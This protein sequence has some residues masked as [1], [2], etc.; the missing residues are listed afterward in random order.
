MPYTVY[1]IRAPNGGV[2]YGLTRSPLLKRW[3]SHIARANKSDRRH[4][5]YDAMRCYGVGTFTCEVVADELT[6]EQACALEIACISAARLNGVRV[7]NIS[8]G[9]E[10][11]GRTGG[12]AFWREIRAD[13]VR[14]AAYLRKCSIAQR[15]AFPKKKDNLRE[16]AK[17]WREDNPKLAYKIRRRATRLSR[18]SALATGRTVVFV[19]TPEYCAK[20]SL[21]QKARWDA[22]PESAKRR[23]AR[24]SRENAR[25]QWEGYSPEK[26]DE[27]RQN[28]SEGCARA[29]RS[30]PSRQEKVAAQLAKSRESIDRSVQGPAASAGLKAY[31]AALRACPGAWACKMA[32]KSDQARKQR[33]GAVK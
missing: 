4:P 23:W 24:R 6:R 32:V 20:Q 27:V 16:G 31:W 15:A 12:V 30:D 14:L 25:R 10:F 7:F 5:L 13:P 3:G 28:I 1:I 17:K 2:Y 11:D 29:Y 21:A 26:R 22:M 8:P 33:L 18:A 19:R 9:G